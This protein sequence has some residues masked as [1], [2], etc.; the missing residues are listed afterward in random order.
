MIPTMTVREFV[1]DLRARGV[2]TS[3]TTERKNIVHGIYPFAHGIDTGKS[4]SCR[5]Y[6]K[7]YLKWVEERETETERG[8]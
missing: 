5:I 1:D 8:A 6:T 3:E 2:S 7:L 4:I